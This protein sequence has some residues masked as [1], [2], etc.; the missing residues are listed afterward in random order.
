MPSTW[1]QANL[2][3]GAG[4]PS[5]TRGA[6]RSTSAKCTPLVQKLSER[7]ESGSH[8]A[9]QS[10]RMPRSP[11]TYGF[12]T[13]MLPWAWPCVLAVNHGEGRLRRLKG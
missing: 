5:P 3:L 1:V 10:N 2:H 7:L 12:A 8:S 4:K 13:A 9:S 11:Q 6:P